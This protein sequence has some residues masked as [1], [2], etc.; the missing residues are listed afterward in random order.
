MKLDILTLKPG[1]CKFCLTPDVPFMFCKD[2]V[3]PG[4]V[5]CAPHHKV[6]HNGFGRDVGS[7]EA[8]MYALDGNVVRRAAERSNTSPVDVVVRGGE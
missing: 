8:M 4:S 6:C 5:Y 7:L 2:P 3:A 1:Q